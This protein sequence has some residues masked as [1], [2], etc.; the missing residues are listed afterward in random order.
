[1]TKFNT[2]GQ[3]VYSTFLGAGSFDS[4]DAIV[5]DSAGSV[6]I[7][8]RTQSSDFPT[9]SALKSTLT[10]GDVDMFVTQ[11]NAAGSSILFSTFFGGSGND[12]PGAMAMDAAG[13]LYVAGI[14]QST[15]FPTLNP[16]QPAKSTNRDSVVARIRTIVPSMSMDKSALIFSAV[17]AGGIL[18]GSTTPQVVRLTQAGS[19]TVTWTATPSASWLAVS[20]ASGS[21]SAT[22]TISLVPG[23]IPP[24][25][26][27]TGTIALAFTGAGTVPSGIGVTLNVITTGASAAPFGSFDTPLEGTAGVTGSIPVTGLGDRRRRGHAGADPPRSGRRRTRRGSSTSATRSSWTAHA[28]TSPRSTPRHHAARAP[29]GAT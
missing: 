23:A 17:S 29:V 8:G 21:G 7:L 25:G 1:M 26:A 12:E 14:S 11:L 4:G 13:D 5:A 3:R 20:P 15:N 22:L 28:P 10:P 2:S 27:Y 6:F 16:F 9:Q 19:G 24:P 18:S